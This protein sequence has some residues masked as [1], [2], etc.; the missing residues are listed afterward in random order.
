MDKPVAQGKDS[1]PAA[2]PPGQL[3]SYSSQ[4]RSSAAP[5]LGN[6]LILWKKHSGTGNY[7]KSK[8]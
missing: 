2:F 3:L 8:F 5:L 1:S 6:N 7:K 4:G